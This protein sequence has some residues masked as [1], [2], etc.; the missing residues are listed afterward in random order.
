MT[1]QMHNKT[2]TTIGDDIRLARLSKGWSQQVLAKRLKVLA[3]S[4]STW[5]RG[6]GHPA[7]KQLPKL[8]E[9]LG[10]ADAAMAHRIMQERS[11]KQEAQ[12]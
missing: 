5:E 4:I 7:A 2:T 10:I 11:A 6:K 1:K 9:F 12:R 3:S 8:A